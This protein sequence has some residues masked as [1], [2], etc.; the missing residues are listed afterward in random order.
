MFRK[1]NLFLAFL[2]VI[3]IISPLAQARG[4]DG[5]HHRKE[6]RGKRHQSQ[7]VKGKHHL[8][9]TAEQRQAIET[10]VTEMKAA[11]AGRSEIKKAV[12][13]MLQDFGVELPERKSQR[14]HQHGGFFNQLTE[15][16]KLLIDS[17]VKDMREAGAN[18]KEIR[19]QVDA[20]L[21]E[22]GIE[23]PTK[24]KRQKLSSEQKAI[25]KQLLAEGASPTQ[26]R[27][28]VAELAIIDS[29]IATA[30]SK[31]LSVRKLR[32]TTLGKVKMNSLK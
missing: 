13:Q 27:Q 9:L 19:K 17:K 16:Q 31:D 29:A 15:E 1:L 28:A 30:P 24:S 25:I 20:I 32:L 12:D 4:R 26:I 14:K 10:K 18:R 7:T 3:L 21:K 22:L 5:L 6:T 11:E 8:E 2:I 23:V